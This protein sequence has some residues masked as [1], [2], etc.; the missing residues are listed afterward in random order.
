MNLQNFEKVHEREFVTIRHNFE[1]KMLWNEW[2]SNIP[3]GPLR[4]AMHFACQY[5]IDNEIELILADYTRML[6]PSLQDQTWIATHAAQILQHSKLK[7][8][9]NIMGTDIFQQISIETIYEL[10]SKY[11]LPCES[12][13]FIFKEDALEWLFSAE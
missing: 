11:P 9:A 1:K 5:I 4:E 8:V 7:R 13:D 6:P 10:A 3:S 2:R 12:R